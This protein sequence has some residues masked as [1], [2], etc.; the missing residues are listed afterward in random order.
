[1]PLR[2]HGS[3]LESG[4]SWLQRIHNGAGS[5]KLELKG[6]H[7][8]SCIHPGRAGWPRGRVVPFLWRAEHCIS[9]MHPG[10]HLKMAMVLQEIWWMWHVGA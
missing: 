10:E 4:A 5:A 8:A 7:W 2:R 3:G 9:A 6:R 1:M